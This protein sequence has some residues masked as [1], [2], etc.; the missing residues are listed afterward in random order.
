M[1]STLAKMG[2]LGTNSPPGLTYL[3]I[4]RVSS[5]SSEIQKVEKL[6]IVNKSIEKYIMIADCVNVGKNVHINQYK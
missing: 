5:F 6:S 3:R 4:S 2:N 1:T